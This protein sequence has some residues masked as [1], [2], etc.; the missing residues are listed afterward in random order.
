MPKVDILAED[1]IVWSY[2]KENSPV[3][4][5]S[6]MLPDV[7]GE[8]FKSRAQ[9]RPTHFKRYVPCRYQ[10]NLERTLNSGSN[11]VD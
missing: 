11:S 10:K 3:E 6:D 1:L 7:V 9:V 2:D 8:W 4:D 5:L